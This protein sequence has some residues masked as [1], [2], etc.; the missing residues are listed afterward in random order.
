LSNIY[1]N[2]ISLGITQL[3]LIH[4]SL[5]LTIFGEDLFDT[6]IYLPSAIYKPIFYISKLQGSYLFLDFKDLDHS[7]VVVDFFFFI[8]FKKNIYKPNFVC[9][10]I[11]TADSHEQHLVQKKK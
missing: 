8:I 10:G 2:K 1:F 9:R 11:D 4:K 3:G 7:D 5:K 6:F